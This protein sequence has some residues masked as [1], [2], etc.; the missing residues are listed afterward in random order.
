MPRSNN[1]SKKKK[2]RVPYKNLGDIYT[3]AVA[4][5]PS[6]GLN[7][8]PINIERLSPEV[9]AQREAEKTA[10]A[11][12][13]LAKAQERET[14]NKEK[15]AEKNSIWITIP[16]QIL[17]AKNIDTASIAGVKIGQNSITPNDQLAW[18]L[19]YR[20][21]NKDVGNG[22]VALYYF[23]KK[24]G[25]EV[26]TKDLQANKDAPDLYI[27]GNQGIE[28]KAYPESDKTFSIGRTNEEM[29]TSKTKTTI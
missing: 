28:V 1:N 19:L 26:T 24:A 16:D 8:T 29:K 20:L 6:I 11:A 10:K 14:K 17:N 3:E 9:K 4:G 21:G 15:Q 25:Y 13:R 5:E 12:E 22:E 23:L 2:V 27:G 7:A 18:E